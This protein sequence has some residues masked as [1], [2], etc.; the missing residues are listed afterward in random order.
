MSYVC[1]YVYVY[2]NGSVYVHVHV[3]VYVDLPLPLSMRVPLAS[4]RLCL[5]V[6]V[7]VDVCHERPAFA[8]LVL[9][10]FDEVVEMDSIYA[11]EGGDKMSSSIS[12]LSKHA[13]F[14]RLNCSIQ[15]V[16]PHFLQPY[17]HSHPLPS[18]F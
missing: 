4:C 6:W 3:Y 18:L 16:R 10:R 15:E 17:P 2:V 11:K 1:I 9:F 14:E 13:V 12:N 5:Y 7:C 8:L